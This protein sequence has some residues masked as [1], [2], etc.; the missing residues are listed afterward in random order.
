MR[1]AEQ[2]TVNWASWLFLALYVALFALLSVLHFVQPGFLRVATYGNPPV[3]RPP[4]SG[5]TSGRRLALADWLVSPENPLTAR[6]IVI[7][8]V[9][10]TGYAVDS[11][12]DNRHLEFA[13]IVVDDHLTAAHER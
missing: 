10:R 6:V 7:H 9:A 8:T 3:E 13:D 4:A 1:T 5:H 12:V 2:V 11:L